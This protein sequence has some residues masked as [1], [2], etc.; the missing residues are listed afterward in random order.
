MPNIFITS[1]LV[2]GGR[3]VPRRE[4][5]IRKFARQSES[6]H[7]LAFKYNIVH[8]CIFN[9]AYE[10]VLLLFVKR[11]LSF[12][13]VSMDDAVEPF[14]R[15]DVELRADDVFESDDDDELSEPDELDFEINDLVPADVDDDDDADADDEYAVLFELNRNN[16]VNDVF[17][18]G[19][20]WIFCCTWTIG[21]W[22]PMHPEK[23]AVSGNHS[24]PLKLLLTVTIGV[25]YAVF[26]MQGHCS[27][28]ALSRY[29]FSVN[30]SH[31]HLS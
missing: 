19:I 16:R 13:Y 21:Y 29:A 9:S 4:L 2:V 26:W 17:H 11:F 15:D 24:N 3:S 23:W 10:P 7:Q 22:F 18:F 28:R 12:L 30:S 25:M 1:R 5:T 8:A 31:F 6:F 20:E 14:G 27:H